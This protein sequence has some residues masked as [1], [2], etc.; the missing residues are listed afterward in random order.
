MEKAI[1]TSKQNSGMAARELDFSY[2]WLWSFKQ[3][4]G[5]SDPKMYGEANAVDA[6]AIKQADEM[7]RKWLT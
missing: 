3:R 6:A 4:V 5:I 2:G 1:E 7:Q